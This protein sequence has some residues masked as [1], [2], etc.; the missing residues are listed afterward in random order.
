MLS[1][2]EKIRRAI[3]LMIPI[4]VVA[5]VDAVAKSIAIERLPEQGSRLNFLIDFAL[6]KNP[7]IAFNIPIPLT[8]VVAVSLII[9]AV[10]GYYSI[11]SFEQFPLRSF[12]AWTV[13]VGA[14]GNM[15]DRIING[16]T[17]DYIILFRMSAINLSDIL[18]LAGVILLFVYNDNRA[19]RTDTGK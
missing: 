6:H 4:C 2:K 16:F 9:T 19:S 15:T 10:L 14:L 8:I 17:T 1:K 12:F 5:L 7:G 18:I 13:I 11:R 3:M